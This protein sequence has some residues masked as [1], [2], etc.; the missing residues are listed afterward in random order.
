MGDF[1]FF[2]QCSAFPVCNHN[3]STIGQGLNT[4]NILK[5]C[6]FI[7]QD[8]LIKISFLLYYKI[9]LQLSIYNN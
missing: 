1:F 7:I 6:Y 2:S 8:Q 3:L 9:Y 5:K 4:V